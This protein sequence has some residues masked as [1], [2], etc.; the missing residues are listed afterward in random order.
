MD[1]FAAMRT[2]VQVVETESFTKAAAALGVSRA[3]VSV[4]VQQLEEQLG[5]RLLHRTT[6][7]VSLTNEGRMYHD[8]ARD[9]LARLDATEQLFRDVRPRASGR[10]TVD[11]PTRIARRILLPALADFLAQHPGLEV[12]LGATDR[13][14]NLVEK[15]VDAVVRVGMLR[16]SSHIVRSLG[17][18]AQ[19]NCASPRYL[20]RHGHPTSLDGLD[21]HLLVN[22]A[23]TLSGAARWDYML[24]G[25]PA[26]RPMRSVVAVDN[27]ETYV[28]AAL[29]GLGLIQIP[30]YDVRHHLESGALVAVLPRQVAPAL[31]ISIMYPSRRQ[32]PPRLEVFVTWVAALF[33]RHRLVE[34]RASAAAPT[35][36]RNVR[37]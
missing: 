18:L 37:P 20:A 27:A 12:R 6:R 26:S 16:D 7:Q 23:P 9:V 24:K 8:G 35:R 5:V 1:R 4:S 36:P 28:A 11:V 13:T 15:G 30:A 21:D 32:V 25:K 17:Q 29:A 10:L 14:I 3:T 31:P 19:V 34:P 33:E 2:F 22:Y